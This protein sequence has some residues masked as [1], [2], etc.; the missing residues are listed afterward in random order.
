MGTLLFEQIVPNFP[1]GLDKFAPQKKTYIYIY[2][3]F[4]PTP[5][6]GFIVCIYRDLF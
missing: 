4:I 5:H 1:P 6:I 2:K 3:C